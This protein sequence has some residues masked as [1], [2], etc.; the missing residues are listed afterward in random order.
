MKTYRKPLISSNDYLL[1]LAITLA[2]ISTTMNIFCMKSLS[3]GSPIIL[4][5]AG[6]LISWGV[7]LISNVITEVWNEKMAIKLVTFSAIVSLFT[8]I[9]ARIIVDIPTLPS[10]YDQADAFAKIFSNGPRT[11]ISS[12]I[13]FLVGNFVNV[14]IIQKIKDRLAENDNHFFFF[15]RAA[16]STLIGQLVDNALFMFLAFAPI[17][18]SVYEM[19]VFDIITAV[20]SGTVIELVVEVCFVPFI[21]IPLTALIKRTIEREKE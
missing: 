17:G 7:F 2:V 21:T 13:A 18:I 16:F 12:I 11:I 20:L 5:D 4:C 10:Y 15:M 9:L 6:L 3:F 19:N 14:H 1:F 8:M